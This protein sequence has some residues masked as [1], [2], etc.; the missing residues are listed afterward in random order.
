M[1]QNTLRVKLC[2]KRPWSGLPSPVHAKKDF[3]IVKRDGY[4]IMCI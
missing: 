3:N 1:F 2:G 4:K